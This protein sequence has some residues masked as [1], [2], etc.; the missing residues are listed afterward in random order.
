M[1]LF[2]LF[3]KEKK[4]PQQVSSEKIEKKRQKKVGVSELMYAYMKRG[5][6]WGDTSLTWNMKNCYPGLKAADAHTNCVEYGIIRKA[7]T[8][9]KLDFA[10]FNQLKAICKELGLK[11]KRT[12]AE[13]VA[14]IADSGCLDEVSHILT[15][16]IIELSEEGK[17]L[18][19]KHDYIPYLVKEAR[20]CPFDYEK[21]WVFREQNPTAPISFVLQAGVNESF[22]A[23]HLFF[24]GWEEID[25]EAYGISQEK[26]EA[27]L[28]RRSDRKAEQVAKDLMEK[29]S[30]D[31]VGGKVHT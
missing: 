13:T 25:E 9:E 21:M 2:N 19:E 6:P 14:V 28:R 16:D 1:G 26:F 3:K 12:K 23:D 17:H 22:I 8:L 29:I 11:A 27:Q 20:N 31:I 4:P 5:N 7:T 10:S 18:L 24:E 15:D 30:N